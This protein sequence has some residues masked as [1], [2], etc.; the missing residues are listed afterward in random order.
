MIKKIIVTLICILALPILV[1]ADMGAPET[2]HYDVIITNPNGVEIEDYNGTKTTI[3][4]DTKITVH[5]EY[6]KDGELYLDVEYNGMY[7]AIRS[8]DV[9][10][11][12]EEIDF[13]QFSE[14]KYGTQLY[15]VGNV[16]MYKGPSTMYGKAGKIIPKGE[17]VKYEYHD[18]MWA[19]L[20]YEG[21]KGWIYIYEYIDMVQLPIVCNVVTLV[22]DDQK[23]LVLK[24]GI[25]IYADR[26]R[27][28]IAGKLEPGEY[29]IK[30]YS[31]TFLR[32]TGYYVETEQLSGWVYLYKDGEDFGTPK[33]D[34]AV[35]LNKS[36]IMH[37]SEEPLYL[38]KEIYDS[39]PTKIKIDKYTL[40]NAQYSVT[41]EVIKAD[42]AN[43]EFVYNQA[44]QVI[45]NGELYWLK[46]D[47]ELFLV[48]YSK[49]LYTLSKD[50]TLLN[51]IESTEPVITIKS[52]ETIEVHI[53]KYF[54]G[55][56]WY[57]IEYGDY[58]GWARSDKIEYSKVEY[59][60]YDDTIIIPEEPTEPEEPTQPVEKKKLT[61]L[62]IG[63]IC[64]GAAIIATLT[65]IVSIILVNKKKK[66]KKEKPVVETTPVEKTTE[67][68]NKIKVPSTTGV[69][70]VVKEEDK[71][72]EE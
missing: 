12:T 10:L 61:G 43:W 69:L 72:D 59:E 28:N 68:D 64:G 7:G 34:E 66:N 14:N 26:A 4:Y 63:F 1:N 32:N 15:T 3:P 17:I 21:T 47:S 9:R 8:K 30:Y 51:G 46:G 49:G 60:G 38:Y 18:S 6:E 56:N 41:T 27:T 54:N 57:Y 16:E 65:A 23:I 5:F 39:T 31:T 19:Y 40:I 35:L 58:K 44:Y 62:Q 67:D 36:G 13:S 70:P 37:T 42:L 22:E 25:S 50:L 11:F 55:E 20:E 2:Y 24:D 48:S 29:D 33:V 53:T 52:G 71:K 45:Y